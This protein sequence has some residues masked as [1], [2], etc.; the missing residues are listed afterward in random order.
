MGSNCCARRRKPPPSLR[1]RKLF[2]G[3]PPTRMHGARRRKPPPSLRRSRPVISTPLVA[4]VR[5][6]ESLRLHCGDFNVRSVN[7]GAFVCAVRGGE[8]LRLHCGLTSDLTADQLIHRARRRK[9]PPSLRPGCRRST[10]RRRRWCARR[11]KPPPSLRHTRENAVKAT[12][13]AGCAR[14]RKPPPSLRPYRPV[15]FGFGEGMG[16][17]R[18]KPPPSLRLSIEKGGDRGTVEVRGGESLRLHCGL[19]IV[20]WAW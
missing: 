12:T 7:G 20:N 16:A 10:R 18:R 2:G 11:R 13:V 17:R 15:L 19:A 5:G 9:P 8:S 6:G 4:Q 1:P 14:R 3:M